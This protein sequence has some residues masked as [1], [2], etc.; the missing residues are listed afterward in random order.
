MC[1]TKLLKQLRDLSSGPAVWDGEGGGRLA[2]PRVLRQA[3]RSLPAVEE[4]HGGVCT[5]TPLSAWKDGDGRH[6]SKAQRVY[7]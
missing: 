2:E 6:P 5:P 4:Q 1:K 3:G 7:S